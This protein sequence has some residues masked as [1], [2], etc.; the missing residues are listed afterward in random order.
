MPHGMVMSGHDPGEA[1]LWQPMIPDLALLLTCFGPWLILRLSVHTEVWLVRSLV[2]L[3]EGD[4]LPLDAD[5]A[6]EL[7]PAIE[8]WR[9]CWPE[10][11]QRPRVHWLSDA[12]D[13]SH[14]PKGEPAALLDRFDA[15]VAALDDKLSVFPPEREPETH[16]LLLEG[17]RDA[18]ALAATLRGDAPVVMTTYG[19][20]GTEPWVCKALD[21][22]GI[23]GHRLSD[24]PLRDA[25]AGPLLHRFARAGLAPL[26]GGGVSRLAALHLATPGCAVP[27][28]PARPMSATIVRGEP[29]EDVLASV[30]EDAPDAS[31]WAN[32]VAIWHE[33]L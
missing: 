29:D 14:A 26:L 22:F 8:L 18:L 4:G 33:V 12:L 3:L 1:T 7:A 21:R 30:F 20:G 2:T 13:Q 23:T 27:L 24:E 17:A 32:A 9:R 6:A 31:L 10:M 25:L 5:E 19:H 16:H 28:P 15:L 11:V